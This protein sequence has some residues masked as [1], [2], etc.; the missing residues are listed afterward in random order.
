VSLETKRNTLFDIK[1]Y[2]EGFDVAAQKAVTIVFRPPTSIPV[3]RYQLSA[4]G[5]GQTDSSARYATR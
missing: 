2:I 1:S 3:T 4:D 5:T